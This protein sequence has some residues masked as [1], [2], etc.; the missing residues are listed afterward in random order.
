MSKTRSHTTLAKQE[1]NLG[2]LNQLP[3]LVTF[4]HKQ[5]PLLSEVVGLV[6]SKHDTGLT[7]QE[8]VKQTASEL[9][10]HWTDRN[11]YTIREVNIT[12]QLNKHVVEYQYLLKRD[13]INKTQPKY[14]RR[15]ED[16]NRAAEN[17]FDIF[18]KDPNRLS[19]LEKEHDIKMTKEDNEVNWICLV[20]QWIY[21]LQQYFF[22]Q[23]PVIF[24]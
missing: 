19:R 3:R 15:C 10:R 1:P 7:Y 5:L 16:F 23:L 21:I 22:Q 6:M 17:L 24:K 4:P 14:I 18:C 2:K 12:K 20:M 8:A 13:T 9:M 11:I